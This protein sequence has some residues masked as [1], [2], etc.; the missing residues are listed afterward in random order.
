MANSKQVCWR[1]TSLWLYQNRTVDGCFL[2][3]SQR[4]LAQTVHA[5][6]CMSIFRALLRIPYINDPISYVY[7]Q[8][9]HIYIYIYICI[10][11]DFA[12]TLIEHVCNISKHTYITLHYLTLHYITYMHVIYLYFLY[13]HA[14]MHTDTHTYIHTHIHAC[15]HTRIYMYIRYILMMCVHSTS[16]HMKDQNVPRIRQERRQKLRDE[17]RRLKEE[18]LQKARCRGGINCNQ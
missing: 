8:D 6:Y 9:T 2:S 7:A 10:C 1:Q 12:Y 5:F 3:Q 4:V 11:V 15:M 13:I 14:C 18:R 16:K 17:R